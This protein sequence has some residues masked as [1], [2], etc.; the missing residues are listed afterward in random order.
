MSRFLKSFRALDLALETQADL[1]CLGSRLVLVIVFFTQLVMSL[2]G[3]TN[4]I[5]EQES[6]LITVITDQL[7]GQYP[8][9]RETKF[10]SPRLPLFMLRNRRAKTL[11]PSLS[12]KN[13]LLKE[14]NA[15][16]DLEGWQCQD[17]RATPV[18]RISWLFGDPRKISGFKIIEQLLVCWILAKFPGVGWQI[19]K[20]KD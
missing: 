10:W 1:G 19:P 5:C 6:L 14:V 12:L 18:T 9:K 7:G 4:W 11:S 13:S 17:L 8:L 16:S 2:I 3:Q 15:P 20:K